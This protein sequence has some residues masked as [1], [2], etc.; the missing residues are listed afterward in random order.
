MYHALR[1][2]IDLLVHFLTTVSA[3]CLTSGLL[4]LE[5][6]SRLWCS[7]ENLWE[8]TGFKSMSPL[9][10]FVSIPVAGRYPNVQHGN[11]PRADSTVGAIQEAGLISGNGR[12]EFGSTMHH[13][14]CLCNIY[15][16]RYHIHSYRSFSAGSHNVYDN[17][18]LW[19][20]VWLHRYPHSL[21][22]SIMLATLVHAGSSSGG[23]PDLLMFGLSDCSLYWKVLEP[24]YFRFCVSVS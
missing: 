16:E 13:L 11:S 20:E 2:A 22:S 1:R 15:A 3:Q 10:W 24:I 19:H 21:F 8:K 7:L 9:Q 12:L 18:G 4:F 5:R 6:S 17:Q 23:W 14:G